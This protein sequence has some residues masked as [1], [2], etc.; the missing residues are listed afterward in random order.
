MDDHF[1]TAFTNLIVSG[2]LHAPMA[3]RTNR[4]RGDLFLVALVVVIIVLLL[5]A[6]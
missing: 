3:R 4:A 2:G 6:R 5:V 1:K